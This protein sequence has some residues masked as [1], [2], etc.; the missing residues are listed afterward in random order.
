MVSSSGSIP[1]PR[2][3]A[4]NKRS[5]PEAFS[6]EYWADDSEALI[7]HTNPVFE[8]FQL[9]ERGKNND[10]T[11][12]CT[13]CKVVFEALKPGRARVHLGKI[14][15]EGIETC[16]KVPNSV[17]A[18]NK[19]APACPPKQATQ[20]EADTRFG[21]TDIP[22]IHSDMFSTTW[23]LC[24]I[25]RCLGCMLGVCYNEAVRQRRDYKEKPKEAKPLTRN[26]KR[27]LL[28]VKRGEPTN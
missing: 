10:C 1:F 18:L 22:I 12:C 2:A 4:L 16:H 6:A 7:E 26:A 24:M 28:K 23:I 13:H 8:H 5:R 20:K 9:Y 21:N 11:G 3:D 15:G 14:N 27:L 19:L 17:H 25:V